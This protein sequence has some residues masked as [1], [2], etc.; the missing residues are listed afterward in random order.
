MYTAVATRYL[1]LLALAPRIVARRAEVV[2]TDACDIYL[3]LITVQALEHQNSD[4]WRRLAEVSRKGGIG[5]GLV[6]ERTLKGSSKEQG[7]RCKVSMKITP[8]PGWGGDGGV[9]RP[10]RCCAS[11]SESHVKV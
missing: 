3:H 10:L 9:G 7:L 8:R 5:E 11:G 2:I 4:S 1:A 6:D